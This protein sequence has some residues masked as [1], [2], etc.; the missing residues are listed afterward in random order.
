MVYMVITLI[1]INNTH[2]STQPFMNTTWV[3]TH[4]VLHWHSSS[5]QWYECFYI[6]ETSTDT[7]H[8]DGFLTNTG[9]KKMFQYRQ[10][11]VDKP[12]P[13]IFLTVTVNTSLPHLFSFIMNLSDKYR[14]TTSYPSSRVEV[15]TILFFRVPFF[16]VQTVSSLVL[17]QTYWWVDF[18]KDIDLT[19]PSF[20][21]SFP[22]FSH[23]KEPP[24]TSFVS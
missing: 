15:N 13:I 10:F 11:Y 16:V 22:L 23:T 4:G 14:S 8:P 18:N 12:D 17:Q 9:G 7:P 20:S 21:F 24:Y 19:L 3:L 5:W 1:P 6:S 2:S